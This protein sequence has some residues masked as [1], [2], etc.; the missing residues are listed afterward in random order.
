MDISSQID[1]MLDLPYWII[2]IL[3]RQVPAEGGGQYFSVEQY[4]LNSS[5]MDAICQ[6]FARLLLK[7]N[8][9]EDIAVLVMPDDSL[10][11]LGDIHVFRPSELPTRLRGV[12]DGYCVVRFGHTTNGK[13]NYATAPVGGVG[14]ECDKMSREA[15]RRYWDTYPQQLLSLAGSEAG[16][17]F[18]R[19]E[20]DSYEAGGQEWTRSRR[21]CPD[22]TGRGRQPRGHTASEARLAGDGER[23]LCRELLWLHEPAG[24]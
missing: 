23:P 15:V 22:G 2:D 9:Y 14:L 6:R 24:P 4:I 5:M 12:G 8:C 3:P 11:S 20:I 17:T 18:Q 7:I 19:L 1:E 10:V 21:D 13:T 16:K